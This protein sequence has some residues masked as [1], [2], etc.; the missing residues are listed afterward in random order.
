[1]A[2]KKGQKKP[3]NS[4]RKPG[5]PNKSSLRVIDDLEAAG[6]NP[7]AELLKALAKVEDP[8]KRIAYLFRLFRFCYPRLNAVDPLELLRRVDQVDG[9]PAAAAPPAALPGAP[10]VA[11]AQALLGLF[12]TQ[13]SRD[14][15]EPPKPAVTVRSDPAK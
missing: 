3:E 10:P 12:L 7:A 1:M 11:N 9:P 4:G 2:F 15:H 14:V 5:T 8:E 13:A 6:I